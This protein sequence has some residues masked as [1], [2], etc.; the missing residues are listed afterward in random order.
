MQLRLC[1]FHEYSKS[2]DRI[3]ISLFEEEVC[4]LFPIPS[5]HQIKVPNPTIDQSIIAEAHPLVVATARHRRGPARVAAGRPPEAP[6]HQPLLHPRLRH[7]REPG[8]ERRGAQGRHALARQPHVVLQDGKEESKLMWTKV[9]WTV[10][11]SSRN[12]STAFFRT[13]E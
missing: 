9:A 11:S 12:L 6:R 10:F 3:L 7:A 8:D 13:S 5:S 1:K 2:L 4:C